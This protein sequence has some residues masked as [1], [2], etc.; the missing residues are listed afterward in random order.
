MKFTEMS[1]TR[2]NID[3]IFTVYD[4]I[5]AAISAAQNAQEALVAFAEAE[6][7]EQHVSTAMSLAH[8]R[9]TIN[10]KDAFYEAENAFLDDSSPAIGDHLLNV[11]R[12]MLSSPHR[13]EMSEALGEITFER[14]EVDVKSASPVV[15]PLMAEENALTTQYEKLY[16]SAQIEFAG[17]LNTVSQM[18]LYKQSPD[19]ATRKAACEAEGAW[20]DAHR[21]E[22][23]SLYDALVKNRTEQAKKMGYENFV[24]LGAI[25]MRRV[26]YSLEDMANYRAQIK[27]DVVPLIALLKRMQYKRIGVENPKFYDDGFS[28]K[29]GNPSPIGTPEQILAAGKEMYRQL[30]PQTSEFIDK[31]FE[32]ELFDVLSKPGKAPG[33][34]CTSIADYKMPFIFSNFNTTSD[35]VNVLTHEAGHAFADYI[36]QR[37]DIPNILREAGMESCEIHS[38]SMEFLTMDYHELFF[39]ENTAL[40]EVAHAEDAMFF[41]PYGTMVD[42]FQHEMYEHPEYTPEARNA[43]WASLEK[44]YRPWLDFEDLPFY[45]RGAGWQR[46]LHI[47][48]NPFYYIDYCLAQTI[49]LQFF[50]AH[51]DNAADT[52][53][54]YLRLVSAAGTKTYPGLVASAG[55][56]NPFSNGVLRRV[57]SRIS[58]WIIA[59][60]AALKA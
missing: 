42:A 15:L 18:N 34:Y 19:R 47:Y 8:I 11:Y 2:P 25:R 40:Y 36:A 53:Q 3:E 7:L 5:C 9:H 39:G 58:D 52:W 1:Y 27:Q 29:Q 26:G 33:G 6:E 43:V 32:N 45:G 12:A 4:R 20:F 16:A 44:Q 55:F 28:F 13:A 17:K 54:R 35:D 14:M 51:M 57:C 23:D 24:E 21:E 22:F 31:M 37:K 46:Q 60:N 56:E 38:M 49:A 41:L 10:T 30:S 59:E 48:E 50:A